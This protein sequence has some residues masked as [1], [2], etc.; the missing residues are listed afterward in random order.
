MITNM[1][2]DVI[3]ERPTARKE[4]HLCSED[5]WLSLENSFLFFS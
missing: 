1:N 3:R 4:I 5:G 2:I